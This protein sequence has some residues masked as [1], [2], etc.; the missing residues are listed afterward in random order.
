MNKTSKLLPTNARRLVRALFAATLLAGSA[1]TWAD[2]S[3]G[4]ISGGIGSVTDGSQSTDTRLLL[5]DEAWEANRPSLTRSLCK[6]CEFR[7]GVGGTYHK[8][9]NTQ[10]VVLP[11]TVMFKDGRYE[12]GVFRFA[13]EQSSSDNDA[14]T[15]Q[16]IAHPY[17][18]TSLSRRFQLY[19]RG[20]LSAFF[21]FGVSYKTEQDILSVTHWNFASQL[22]IRVQSPHLPAT[23]EF[24]ARHWSNGGVRTPNRGQDF[25]V[26][27]VSF[28][29]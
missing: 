6:S 4:D 8:F 23:F 22:G 5:S 14:H 28:D 24:S 25:A 18:G 2:E 7:L 15:N 16:L 21:G 27:T 3:G 26:L 17:W 13:T 29:R 1:V 19:D 10:G 12:F 11:L 20:P 9:V